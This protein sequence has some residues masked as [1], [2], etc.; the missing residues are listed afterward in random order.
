MASVEKREKGWNGRGGPRKKKGESFLRQKGGM[1]VST[2]D[3]LKKGGNVS[4]D[5][6]R[7]ARRSSGPHVIPGGRERTRKVAECSRVPVRAR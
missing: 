2:Y 1:R 6:T 5:N 4:R 7:E 3:Q